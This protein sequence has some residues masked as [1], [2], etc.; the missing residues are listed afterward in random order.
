[1]QIKTHCDSCSRPI[2][3]NPRAAHKRFCSAGCR[4]AWH[5]AE[6]AE[7]REE[8]RRRKEEMMRKDSGNE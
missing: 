2:E 1:M 5:A 3:P 7:V 6:R 4:N 8:L